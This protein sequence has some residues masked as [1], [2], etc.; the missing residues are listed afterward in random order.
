MRVK[1]PGATIVLTGIFPRN[2]NM[3]VVPTIDRINR[4]IAQFANGTSI[5]YLDVNRMLA[6]AGGTLFDGMMDARDKLH[7]TLE[8]YQVWANALKPILADLLGPPGAED[9]AP[10]PTGD[11]SASTRHAQSVSIPH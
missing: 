11:P 1:A 3:A 5:R 10:Q 9:R 8:G 4:R 2:D 6:D 7:P